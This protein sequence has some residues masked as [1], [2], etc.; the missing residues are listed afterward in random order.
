MPSARGVDK[1]QI[2]ARIC[3]E[4]RKQLDVLTASARSARDG[5]TNDESRAEDKYD[6]RG[7]EASYLA[8][9]QAG[10]AEELK[11]LLHVYEHLELKPHPRGQPARAASLVT[12]EHEGDRGLYFLAPEGRPMTLQLGARSVQVITPASPL[13]DAVLGKHPGDSVEIESR[14]GVREYDVIAIA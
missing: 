10:R 14:A 11:R 13:G 2:V 4:L 5:A 3:E 6:T 8:G 12:L 1:A 7:L 9:A